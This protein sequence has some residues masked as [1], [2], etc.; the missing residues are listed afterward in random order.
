MQQSWQRQRLG[1]NGKKRRKKATLL[2]K[3]GGGVSRRGNVRDL[4]R[5][6]PAGMRTTAHIITTMS[7]AKRVRAA[8]ASRH[9]RLDSQI[10]IVY[11][12]LIIIIDHAEPFSRPRQLS[13]QDTPA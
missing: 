4:L 12:F 5:S 9:G 10:I 6:I 13:A 2:S 1:E 3:E 11:V 8:T 7:S